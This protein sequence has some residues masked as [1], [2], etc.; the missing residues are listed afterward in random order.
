VHGAVGKQGEDGGADVTATSPR[1]TAAAPGT[2]PEAGTEVESPS[3]GELLAAMAPGMA[4]M[5]M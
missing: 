2:R 5:A 4:R 1:P 3:A